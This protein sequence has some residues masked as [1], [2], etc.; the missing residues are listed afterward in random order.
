MAILV[1]G[2]MS[3]TEFEDCPVGTVVSGR[4]DSVVPPQPFS[5]PTLFAGT[6]VVSS[7]SQF[8]SSMAGASGSGMGGGASSE[9]LDH[10]V[11][12]ERD[13]L[14]TCQLIVKLVESCN[15][16][17]PSFN[18]RCRVIVED[19]NKHVMSVLEGYKTPS[20]DVDSSDLSE[21]EQRTT[22]LCQQEKIDK[23][24]R[25]QQHVKHDV[26]ANST[27]TMDQL[28]DILSKFDR[29]TVPK[30]EPYNM[31]A[32]Q[33]FEDFLAL[34]E[35]YCSNSY[36]GSSRL[37]IG[38]LGRLLDGDISVAFQALRSPSDNYEVIKGK[39]VQWHFDNKDLHIRERRGNFCEAVKVAGESTRLYAARLE[40]MFRLAYPRKRVELSK[41][42]KEKFYQTVPAPL[43]QQ[44]STMRNIGI[45]MHKTD[46][47]W[48]TIL[49]LA[50]AYD[51]EHCASPNSNSAVPVFIGAVS[52][53]HSVM[54]AVTQCGEINTLNGSG[55]HSFGRS[56]R[57]V[58][59]DTQSQRQ[60]RRSGS[61]SRNLTCFYCKKKGHIKE[62]CR[63]LKGLC[64]ACGAPDH[65][66]SQCP[67]RAALMQSVQNNNPLN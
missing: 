34:F 49:V 52:A 22:K 55:E 59:R 56:G 62:E 44:I 5:C 33:D 32:G 15:H 24:S 8:A 46:I 29:R 2:K 23:G 28:T 1:V 13:L 30:P 60:Q 47:P 58:M 42:L 25:V 61:S 54:D 17:L 3:D 10:N 9:N 66:I 12:E 4:S 20:R 63:K 39:L 35:E 45:S 6:T 36:C 18:S 31:S 26:S 38:E 48:S 19:M 16:R 57:D 65:K 11:D 51:S 53:S 40:K 21:D 27:V 41:T 43:Q 37:W 67:S 7:A 64:L 14:N 50:T